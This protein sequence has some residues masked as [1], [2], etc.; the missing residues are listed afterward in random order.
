MKKTI[1]ILLV[2][3]S[4]SLFGQSLSKV[5]SLLNAAQEQTEELKINNDT[6]LGLKIGVGASILALLVIV[7]I[8]V[9]RT[10]QVERKSKE[11]KK[12]LEKVQTKNGYL[13][14]ISFM[15]SHD[16]KGALENFSFV[17]EAIKMTITP[18]QLKGFGIDE[19]IELGDNSVVQQQDILNGIKTWS[20][21]VSGKQLVKEKF[22]A[23]T[24]VNEFINSLGYRN[25]A[26][27]DVHDL[28]HIEGD[29]S[30][31]VRV[32]DNLVRNG[33]IHN[34]KDKKTL[35]IYREK[36]SI[37]IKDNGKGFP[38]DQFEKLKKPF[39]RLDESTK[40]DG[41]GLCIIDSIIKEHDWYFGV[42]S[43]KNE[44]TN[45]EIKIN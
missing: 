4:L 19:F 33:I 44:W 26:S 45:F 38:V 30:L 17:I 1:T 9:V 39:Q 23:T 22:N 13:E 42:T 15:A 14:Q 11:L 16:M 10:V 40:G 6:G 21:L 41:L 32:M 18:E 28:G 29:K 3:L 20:S 31:F 5:Y 25:K 8:S 35:K 27:I 24:V 43:K 2:S 37:L 36:D 7:G 12:T 34:N